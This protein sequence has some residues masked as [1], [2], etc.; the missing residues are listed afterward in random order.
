MAKA[1]MLPSTLERVME[2][3]IAQTNEFLAQIGL[4]SQDSN[5]GNDLGTTNKQPAKRRAPERQQDVERKPKRAR[6]ID[7]KEPA[8]RERLDSDIVLLLT[9]DPHLWSTKVDLSYDSADAES[10]SGSSDGEDDADDDDDDD[11]DDSS[12]EWSSE[13][14]EESDALSVRARLSEWNYRL[15]GRGIRKTIGTPGWLEAFLRDIRQDLK[16]CIRWDKD[17]LERYRDVLRKCTESWVP[18]DRF[19]QYEEGSTEGAINS[20][21]E[22]GFFG[23]RSFLYDSVKC[24][25]T[26]AEHCYRM[27]VTLEDVN[28]GIDAYLRYLPE[29]YLRLANFQDPESYLRLGSPSVSRPI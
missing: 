18:Y 22:E 2:G 25:H 29:S 11:D 19:D 26:I 10:E 14:E 3:K 15:P 23:I 17:A 9:T 20:F 24:I 7:L 16:C 13:E 21:H 28:H 8:F 6:K 1:E 27:H 12:I 4:G 5:A